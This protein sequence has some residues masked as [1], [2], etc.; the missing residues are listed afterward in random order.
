MTSA[1]GT[2]GIMPIPGFYQ[3]GL[4][5]LLAFTPYVATVVCAAL[6][7]W[8]M[9]AAMRGR[10]RENLQ[11]LLIVIPALTAELL[12][13]RYGFE[14]ELLQGGV[15]CFALLYASVSDISTREVPDYIPV[16]IAVAALIGREPDDLLFMLC[17]AVIISLPQL[18]I[19]L[20]KPGSYGGGD[21]KIM[22]ACAFLL[23]LGRGLTAI[24]IGL[25]L[26]VLCTAIVRKAR[27]QPMKA[28]FP[29][30]PYLSVGSMIA[31]F[32]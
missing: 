1:I 19:A 8:A 14:P 4:D 11:P 16:F 9:A 12:T 28:G 13:F 27:R 2:A 18:A 22:A 24:L 10:S 29:L 25:L 21:I 7:G 6:A 23:G 32:L 20:L 5:A 26:A 31:Y 17:S 15:L 30:V 3:T